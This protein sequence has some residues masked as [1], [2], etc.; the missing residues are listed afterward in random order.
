[1]A[2]TSKADSAETMRAQVS[3]RRL[4]GIAGGAAGA[5]I[6]APTAGAP[7][8]ATGAAGAEGMAAIVASQAT[9]VPEG[10]TP[11]VDYFPS[12]APGVP[13]AY[14]RFPTPFK[15]V[16][17]VPGD[18]GPVSVFQITFN[19]PVAPREENGYWQE[20]EQRLGVSPLAIDFAPSNSYQERLATLTA[21]GDLPD[22]VYLDLGL[23]PSQ[24]E[25][26]RQGAYTDLTPYLAG[27]A[28]QKYPNLARLPDYMWENSA[29]D[30][31]IYGVPRS[32]YTIGLPIWFRQDWA[33]KVRIPEPKNADEFFDLLVAFTQD[34]PDGN[35][36]TDTWGLGSPETDPFGLSRL[37]FMFRVPNGWRLNDDGTLVAALETDEY[38]QMV[39]YARRLYEAGVYHP[40][41]ATMSGTELSDAF[42]AGKIGGA[43]GGSLSLP[44][45]NGLR[46]Y[47]K[48]IF[49]NA[50]V[51]ALIPPGHDGGPPLTHLPSGFLGPVAIPAK[52]GEDT[53]RLEELLRI[54]NFYAAPFGSEEQVFSFFGI[55]GVHSELQ[56]DGSRVRTDLF[57]EEI[58]DIPNLV[59]Y[60]PAYY[61]DVPGDAKYM[62][63]LAAEYVALGVQNPTLGLYSPTMVEEGSVLGQLATDRQ[64]A[65]ITG[66]EPVD[67]LDD[68]VTEW[69]GRGGD[70]MR[71]EYEEALAAR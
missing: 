3:R 71:A 49:P 14:A 40:D 23:A 28:L 43:V 59:T 38:R 51:V 61:F 45:T 16:D 19:P 70:R 18:G 8:S 50:E 37:Q 54:L 30:G 63:D 6:L 58:L 33:E 10:L 36:Q 64:I 9:P 7:A 65:V 26:I 52:V 4:L 56:P 34:D 62:Q 32:S 2:K 15:S 13:E 47:T 20:R 31:K 66:R 60:P 53:E 57:R 41:S 1:M 25:T 55:D 12:P 67:A 27:D 21:S 46:Q 29:I 17:G 22:L 11:G 42:V 35:G 68:L 39:A 69:R 24:Y 48:Q 5:A 44:G